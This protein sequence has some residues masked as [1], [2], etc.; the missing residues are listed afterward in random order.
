MMTYR[1]PKF[2]GKSQIALSSGH[3][4]DT[5]HHHGASRR[6]SAVARA[7]ATDGSADVV[8]RPF[9]YPWE[10]ARSQLGLGEHDL[11]QLHFVPRGPPARAC[12]T[13]GGPTPL[14]TWC[15]D[16]ASCLTIRFQR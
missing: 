1:S 4:C 13:L 2:G 5:E 7:D 3:E 9:S 6:H 14:Y 11:A 8:R 12:R 15:P 10:L 16:R